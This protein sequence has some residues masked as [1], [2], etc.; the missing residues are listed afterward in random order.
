[1][2][3]RRHDPVRGTATLRDV[4]IS[5]LDWEGPS[6]GAPVLLLLHGV[7]GCAADWSRVAPALAGEY[8]VLAPDQRGHGAST[9]PAAPGGYATRD[10]LGDLEAF[11]D[12]L[13]IARF[14]VLGHGMGGHNAIGLAARRTNRV[15]CAL[16]NDVQPAPDAGAARWEETLGGRDHPVFP[17]V[18]DYVTWRRRA[19][20][21]APAALLEE[22][23]GWRLAGRLDGLRAVS[24][25]RAALDWRP[26]DLWEEAA[27]IRCPILYIRGGR[28]PD[29]DA[30]TQQRMVMQTPSARSVSLELAG[31]VTYL[32]REEEFIGMARAFFA[33]HMLHA[34]G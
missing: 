17:T 5:Y 7:M 27:G 12:A 20:P 8:R 22:E 26:D 25:V 33:A 28:S 14:G 30:A 1:M 16:A 2:G 18:G 11:T 9:H 24:D 4:E 23:A 32:D 21:A 10:Y 15:L 13:G 31:H 6:P 3:E 34:Q 29:L 19:V